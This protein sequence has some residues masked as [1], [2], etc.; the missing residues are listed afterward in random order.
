MN[1]LGHGHTDHV[2][3]CDQEWM[4]E[5]TWNCVRS[6]REGFL[7]V[8]CMDPDLKLDMRPL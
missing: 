8:F 5:D 4:I 1:V 2:V 6:S 3:L 7:V